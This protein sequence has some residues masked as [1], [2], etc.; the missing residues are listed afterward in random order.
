MLRAE[1]F[2]VTLGAKKSV[3]LRAGVAVADVPTPGFGRLTTCAQGPGATLT[4]AF[5][6]IRD[7]PDAAA[8][9][10]QLTPL[11]FLPASAE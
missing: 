8:W 4:L 7:V 10:A 6:V 3:V 1:G 11:N 2:L 9:G 5:T